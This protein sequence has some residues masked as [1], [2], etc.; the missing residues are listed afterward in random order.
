MSVLPH[1]TVSSMSIEYLVVV[2]KGVRAHNV[3]KKQGNV[4]QCEIKI[5][6]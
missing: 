5:N 4:A 1:R 6:F 3:T 2:Q